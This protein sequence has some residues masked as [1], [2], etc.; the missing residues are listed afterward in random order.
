MGGQLVATS[1]ASDNE[2]S[3]RELMLVFFVIER[4]FR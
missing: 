1:L 3:E 4:G 2:E